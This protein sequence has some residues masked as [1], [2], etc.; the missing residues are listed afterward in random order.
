VCC[1]IWLK[2]VPASIMAIERMVWPRSMRK[3][4][5]PRRIFWVEE[6]NNAPCGKKVLDISPSRVAAV[7]AIVYAD[8]FPVKRKDDVCAEGVLYAA[9]VQ[10]S[11][12]WNSARP[13]MKKGTRQ[14]GEVVPRRM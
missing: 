3:R 5:M 9:V 4:P 14:R 1:T 12:K 11:R 8:P 13:A 6:E 2:L 10:N 7:W